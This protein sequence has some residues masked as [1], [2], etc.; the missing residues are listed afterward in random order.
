MDYDV[1]GNLKFEGSLI[2]RAQRFSPEEIKQINQAKG[3]SQTSSQQ[4]QNYYQQSSKVNSVVKDEPQKNNNNIGGILAIVGAVS[5]LIA[6][7]VAVVKG[8]FKKKI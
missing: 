6:V 7:S 3:I 1:M 8:R 4:G 5:V 2:Y